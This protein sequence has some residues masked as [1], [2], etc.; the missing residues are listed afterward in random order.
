[1]S[2][3]HPKPHFF[4]PTHFIQT[5]GQSQQQNGIAPNLMVVDPLADLQASLGGGAQGGMG[6]L[7]PNMAGSYPGVATP[8][9]SMSGYSGGSVGGSLPMYGHVDAGSGS[10]MYTQ[11]AMTNGG[12]GVLSTSRPYMG[13]AVQSPAPTQVSGKASAFM[14]PANDLMAPGMTQNMEAMMY[15]M[16]LMPQVGCHIFLTVWKCGLI[17]FAWIGS[18]EFHVDDIR[19]AILLDMF[20][21]GYG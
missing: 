6:G 15:N 20:K 12:M 16:N 4:T 3:S 7:S 18:L 1:M 17:S 21:E 11:A 9:M 13:E 10:A 14:T 2:P 5:Q 8:N 19:Y